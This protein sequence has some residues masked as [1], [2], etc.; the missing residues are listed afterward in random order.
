MEPNFI[1]RTAWKRT[2]PTVWG[3]SQLSGSLLALCFYLVLVVVATNAVGVLEV[4]GLIVLGSETNIGAAGVN[5][6]I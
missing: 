4:I 1:E 3:S 5:F 6:S 2:F